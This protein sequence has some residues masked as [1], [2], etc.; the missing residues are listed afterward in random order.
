[1][2]VS[3][4]LIGIL[5]MIAVP[6]YSAWI[7]NQQIR[8]GAES[9]L[10]GIQLARSTAVGNNTTAR[11][12]LCDIGNNNTSWEVLATSA[13]AAAPA[14]SKACAGGNP[15]SAAAANNVRV[16]ER[17]YKEGSAFVQ[18]AVNGGAI[19]S[20]AVTTITFNNLGRVVANVPASPSIAQVNLTNPLTANAAKSRPLWVT[21]AAPGGSTKMCDPTLTAGS[22]PRA[23]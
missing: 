9:I 21:V 17:Y 13:G 15:G 10:N 16:Q 6:T 20:T 8:A 1:M 18:A 3:I 2:L 4:T 23:C 5:F 11:F 12:V 14:L 7:Q 19:G 22:D